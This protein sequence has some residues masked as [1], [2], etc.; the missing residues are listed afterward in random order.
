MTLGLPLSTLYAFTLVLARV[1]GLILFLPVPGFRSAPDSVRVFLALAIAFALFPVWPVLPNVEPSIGQLAAWAF[2]EAGFGLIVGLAV[3]FLIEGFQVAAQVAGVHAGF[4]FATTIDPTSEADAGV[5]QVL[6]SLF[7]GILFFTVGMDRQL[8]RV[9]AASFVRFPAGSWEPSTAGL[10][11]IVRLG[12][13]MLSLELRLALPVVALLI[14]IDFALALLGRVQQH[15]QLLSMAFPAKM[16]SALAIL[17]ALAAVVPR[18]FSSAAGH[19][20]AVLRRV[21]GS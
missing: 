10:D 15:L 21:L 1:A 4:G 5:L 18:M 20:L 17:A 8:I 13:D 16:A 2:S 3:A 9:L 6:A 12:S 7:S 14:L 19:T 11:G